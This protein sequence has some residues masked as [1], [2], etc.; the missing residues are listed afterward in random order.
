MV[1]EKTVSVRL[2]VERNSRQLIGAQLNGHITAPV[3]TGATEA[4]AMHS[5][6]L[7]TD[8]SRYKISI[9]GKTEKFNPLPF[10]VLYCI[11]ATYQSCAGRRWPESYVLG[12]MCAALR[13]KLDRQKRN[14]DSSRDFKKLWIDWT[15][16]ARKAIGAIF[17]EDW[18]SDLIIDGKKNRRCGQRPRIPVSCTITGVDKKLWL[19]RE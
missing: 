8:G 14:W 15:H 1:V 11:L 17:S 18:A 19:E 13:K 3:M 10:S 4:A 12:E 7:S 5:I 2:L 16:Q 6:Q 9:N